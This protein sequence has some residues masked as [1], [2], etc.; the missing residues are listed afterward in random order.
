MTFV[1]RLRAF[2]RRWF[3]WHGRHVSE[4]LA[5]TTTHADH[6]LVLAVTEPTR[7]PRWTQLRLFSQVVSVEERRVFW[8]SLIVGIFCIAVGAGDLIY[9][10]LEPAPRV[11]G[12]YTEALIGSPKSINPLFASANDVDRDLV[13]L[14]YSGLF[15][16]DARME[17]VPDLAERYTWLDEKTLEVRLRADARFH[18]GQ[19]VTADDVVFTFDAAKNPAWRS[20]LLPIFRSVKTLRIDDVTVQL[21]LDKPFPGILAYLTTGILPAH[22]WQDVVET[23]A[24]IAEANLKPI[25]SGPYRVESFTRD[26]K[27][28]ILTYRLTRFSRYYGQKPYIE[29][30]QFKF[31]PDHTMALDGLANH[32]VDGVAF[33]PWTLASKTQI[34]STIQRSLELPQV[35]V[36]FFNT[37][38][39]LLKEDKIRQALS[40]AIDREEL[41][42]LV[43]GQAGSATSPF[44]FLETTS[45]KA[46]N[47][48]SARMLLDELGWKEQ[49][50]AGAPRVYVAPTPRTTTNSRTRAAA[51]TPTSTIATASSTLFTLTIDVP[52]QEDLIAVANWLKRRWGLIGA[53]VDVHVEMAETLRKRVTTDRT[54]Q[55]LL[56]NILPTPDQD[57]TAFWSSTQTAEYGLNFSQIADRTIDTAIESL[58]AATTTSAIHASRLK[59]LQAIEGRTPAI[60]LLRPRYAYFVSD[61]VRIPATEPVF[62][63][64]NPSDRLL[65]SVDWYVTTG[66]RWKD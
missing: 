11:G 56:W 16:L 54:Y 62:K 35:T 34:P 29:T 36:A 31:F 4:E 58:K 21:Q 15:R 32:Q 40:L 3:F 44:P 46:G 57:V 7:V 50:E 28:S 42:R 41:E 48:E 18:D 26:A 25:G 37:K 23:N 64:A 45:T 13:A 66:W 12:S 5:P 63:L 60:F 53:Q 52:A 1:E 33:L 24:Q 43:K 17:P 9:P 51:T 47:L 14:I 10:H 30:L 8:F 20:P 61:R 2:F 38:D 6:A 22:I 59:L 65:Q 49:T 19:P 27:G 55:V 39:K